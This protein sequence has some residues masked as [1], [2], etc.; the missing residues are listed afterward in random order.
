MS[1][2]NH[3]I[4]VVL[5]SCLQDVRDDVLAAMTLGMT[6]ILVKTGTRSFVRSLRER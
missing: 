1:M 4:V 3:H 6:G 2:T 5:A